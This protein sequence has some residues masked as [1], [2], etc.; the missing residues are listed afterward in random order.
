MSVAM[1]AAT[2]D[3]RTRRRARFY[4]FSSL[5]R[6][7]VTGSSV[8]VGRAAW[9]CARPVEPATA[10]VGFVALLPPGVGS[11]PRPPTRTIRAP[12]LGLEQG[13]SIPTSPATALASI[14]LQT[15]YGSSGTVVVAVAGE[16]DMATAPDLHTAL[17]N[18]LVVYRP[19]VIEVDL[20]A[21]TF[22]DCSG[23]RALIGAHTA[24]QASG[25]PIWIRHPQRFVRLVLEV[26]RMLDMF[27]APD[28]GPDDKARQTAHRDDPAI[29]ASGV[30][31]EQEK[32]KPPSLL[33]A[34]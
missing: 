8:R 6:S 21:C 20:S 14:H 25:C 5:F 27:T 15:R 3:H 23:L 13:M 30:P 18:A 1:L 4:S 29:T 32:D 17:L 34:A 24:A 16:V 22:L 10:A 28:D 12:P 9:D 7:A 2:G 19:A 26:T 11:C 33:A 31:I